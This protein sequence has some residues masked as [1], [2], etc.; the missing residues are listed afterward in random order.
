LEENEY[1]PKKEVST[2]FNS[3]VPILRKL[4]KIIFGQNRPDLYTR[5]SCKVNLFIWLIFF[6]WH[7]ISYTTILM[8]DVV[9][10]LKKIDIEAIIIERGNVLGFDESAFLNHLLNYHLVSIFCWG[11]IFFSILLAWRKN[12][13]FIYLFIPACM[14]YLFSLLFYMGI[15]YFIQDTTTFDKVVFL[16]LNVNSIIFTSF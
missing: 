14:F 13:K 5:I 1:T 3:P 6:L 12:L 7:V 11:L 2:K 10:D 16:I 15:Q 8:R 9:L 4:Q